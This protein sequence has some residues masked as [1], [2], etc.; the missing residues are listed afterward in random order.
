MRD[1]RRIP[2]MLDLLGQIW[3]KCPDMRLG[4]I[5]VNATGHTGDMFH[6]ED[7]EVIDKLRDFLSK[8]EGTPTKD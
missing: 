3:V 1:E 5:L 2:I 8:L 4:Q 6:I 7:T